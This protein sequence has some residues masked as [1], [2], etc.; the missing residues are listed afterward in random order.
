MT[1]SNRLSFEYLDEQGDSELLK[2]MEAKMIALNVEAWAGVEATLKCS[3]YDFLLFV[4]CTIGIGTGIWIGIG[5][6]IE[7]LILSEN[8]LMCI[9]VLFCDTIFC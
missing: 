6:I 3:Q 8:C 1:C 4:L 9:L 2:D 7:T 5:V